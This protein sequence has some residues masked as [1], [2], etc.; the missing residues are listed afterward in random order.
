M[1]KKLHVRKTIVTVILLNVFQIG[2][3]LG[4]TIYY[5]MSTGRL[6]N[7]LILL[8]LFI[9]SVL[10]SS[11]ITIKDAMLTDDAKMQYDQVQETISYL[12][13]LNNT[14]RSQRHDFMN[15]LQVVYSLIEM[16]EYSNAKEYIEK[17]YDD[18]Q[19]VSNVLRTSNPAINALLEA[20]SL[21]CERRNITMKLNISTRLKSLPVH[22]WE[23]CR[24]LA[25][26]IDNAI[27]ALDI[28]KKQKILQI[29]IFEDLNYL[30]FEVID[31]GKGIPEENI[32]KIFNPGFSTKGDKG[33]GMGLAISKKIVTEH[34]GTINVTSK[35]GTTAFKILLPKHQ[36]TQV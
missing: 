23:M 29:N 2:A 19:K 28:D 1:K 3:V 34:G 7:N 27:D 33:E 9:L 14:L 18:I 32:E 11:F 13:N 26:L 35:N 8:I 20:K 17:V 4:I 6:L 36:K 10:V 30:Y 5:T 21:D 12:E 22:S 15:N 16:D 24:V 25:N 31:N